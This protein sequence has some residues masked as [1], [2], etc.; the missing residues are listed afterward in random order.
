[1]LDQG[2]VDNIIHVQLESPWH[3]HLPLAGK[4]HKM[5]DD[6]IY[7]RFQTLCFDGNAVRIIGFYRFLLDVGSSSLSSVAHTDLLEGK[8]AVVELISNKDR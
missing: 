1:M 7:V 2:I 5:G 4:I 8:I 3:G 6:F